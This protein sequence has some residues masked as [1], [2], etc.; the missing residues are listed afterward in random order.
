MNSMPLHAAK[1]NIFWV[2]F[3]EWKDKT[4][5]VLYAESKFERY[6]GLKIAALLV[7]MI[8]HMWGFGGSVM[9]DSVFVYVTSAV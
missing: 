6:F 3:V 8:Y 4:N 2:E 1:T 5:K 7:K 9:I